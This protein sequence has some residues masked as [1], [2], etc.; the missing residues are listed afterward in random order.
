MTCLNSTFPDELEFIFQVRGSSINSS[1][2]SPMVPAIKVMAISE[3]L[4]S[5][6]ST[7]SEKWSLILPSH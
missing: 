2:N 7:A 5:V 6:L 1:L 3:C 4:V